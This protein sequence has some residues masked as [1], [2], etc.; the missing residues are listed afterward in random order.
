[1]LACP[2]CRKLYPSDA[3]ECPDHRRALVPLDSLPDEEAAL[4]PGQMVDE[5][6]V[7]RKLGSGTF[8]AVYA[9]EQ[10]LIGKRVA[11]KVLHRKFDS[12]AGVVSRF[13]S[14]A[15]AVNRIGHR[16]II[17][18]FSFGTLKGNR[19]YFVME[20][21]E[22][23]TLGELLNR[24][25]RIGLR[26]AIPIVRGIADGLDAAHDAG[27]THRDLKPDNIFLAAE[28]GGG[29][30]PKLL[31]FGVAK[32]AGEEVA[33]KTATGAV[34]GT[35]NYMAPEQCRG[36]RI[37][38]RADIYSLG[39]V[40]HEMLTGH[41]LFKA[42][43]AMDVLMMHVSE[44]PRPMSEIFPE[45]PRELDA[46][47]L[48][49]L[50]KSPNQRPRSAGVAVDALVER[51]QALGADRPKATGPREPSSFERS[52]ARRE[53]AT[54]VGG[55]AGAAEAPSTT[56]PV[57]SGDDVPPPGDASAVPVLAAPAATSDGRFAISSKGAT[58]KVWDL[59]TGQAVHTFQGQPDQAPPGN[60]APAEGSPGATATPPRTLGIPERGAATRLTAAAATAH[61]P[62]EPEPAPAP[63]PAKRGARSRWWA[64]SAA[65]A[66]AIVAGVVAFQKGGAPP[67]LPVS[68]DTGVAAAPPSNRVTL[69]LVVTPPDADVFLDG[70]HVGSASEPLVLLRSDQRRS[71]RIEKSGFET[72][73]LWIVADRDRE[74][75]KILLQP[76]P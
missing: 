16:N 26:E 37:D 17:D 46:P 33:H 71:L 8:G 61:A 55:G 68:A 38:H 25:K 11:I 63:A 66:A 40:I 50:A 31:D 75:P 28:K 67:P 41:R 57:S 51:I 15:R 10:P 64:I 58:I 2:E 39:V 1:M 23:M 73:T 35:P 60:Q 36:K 49:M 59:R 45:L 62:N 27:I 6:R 3:T 43:S 18:I 65:G 29:H 24:E 47:V 72:R 19:P 22:G 5:Y 53:A 76:S 14:E 13:V 48:A 20:L 30:F 54:V 56:A 32:L 70:L 7:D 44:P 42:D 21:L 34:I 4:E 74:L 12:D 69:R 9:G 52:L